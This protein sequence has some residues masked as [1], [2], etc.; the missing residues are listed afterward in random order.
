MLYAA[1]PHAPA[2][3]AGG[4]A[5]LASMAE[6]VTRNRPKR[7]EWNEVPQ[8]TSTSLLTMQKTLF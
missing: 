6:F 1:M 2:V 8:R 7:G 5:F 4:I 3:V